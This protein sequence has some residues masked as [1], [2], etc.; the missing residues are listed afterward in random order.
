[1]SILF[2]T[3]NRG[4]WH[5]NSGFLA[6]QIGKLYFVPVDNATGYAFSFPIDSLDRLGVRPRRWRALPTSQSSYRGI[7]CRM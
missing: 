6:L 1:M 7:R 5:S 4:F 2:G 3:P